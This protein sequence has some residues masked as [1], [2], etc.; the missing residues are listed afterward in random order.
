MHAVPSPR[1]RS[2]GTTRGAPPSSRIATAGLSPGRVAVQ[3]RGAYDVITADGEVRARITGRLRHG[4]RRD[5]DCPSSATGSRSTARAASIVGRAPSPNEALAPRR[6]R[7]SARTTF[8]SR[9]I[10]ANLDV[11]FIAA[12]LGDELDARL[13]ERYVTLALES[14]ARP[15]ILL[16]KADLEPDPERLRRRLAGIGGRDPHP[17]RCRPARARPRCACARTS[18]RASRARCS[19]LGRRQVDARQRPRGTTTFS[20]RR[21]VRADGRDGTRRRAASSSILPG[22]GLIVDNPGMREV[23]LW[24]ARRRARRRLRRT[25]RRSR[26]SAGSP[27]AATRPSPAAP[28]RPRWPT[29]DSTPERWERYRVARS[30]ELAELEERLARRERSRARR[31][32]PG[33]G[34]S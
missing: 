2:A 24:L 11:V 28:F 25:S 15:V 3:H 20:R 1:R 17:S 26:P 6:P 23:H 33:A 13:L 22:G 12:S 7:P 8:A 34:A 30:D 18:H 14:G 21:A 32:R 16:T 31:R 19:A 5:R 4:A 9:S 27:T 29:A 10:A